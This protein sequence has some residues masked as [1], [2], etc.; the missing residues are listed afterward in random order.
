MGQDSDRDYWNQTCQ[1][2]EEQDK[3]MPESKSKCKWLFSLA[4]TNLAEFCKSCSL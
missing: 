3:N 2:A 1:E 4:Q